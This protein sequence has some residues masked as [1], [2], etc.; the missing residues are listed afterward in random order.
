MA[1]SPRNASFSEK[2]V[3]SC[4]SPVRSNV[5]TSLC[6]CF[7]L[8]FHVSCGSFQLHFFGG[9][10]RDRLGLLIVNS[11]CMQR[12]SLSR[13]NVIASFS[14]CFY[15]FLSF[16]DSFQLHIVGGS[17]K[18]QIGFTAYYLLLYTAFYLKKQ[19]FIRVFP[20]P[21]QCYHVPF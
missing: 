21:F 14:E 6:D 4:V 11:N 16:S 17:Q 3:A 10:R 5:V 15:H 2:R 7:Y 18:H 19:I 20:F 8:R 1:T 12:F 13:F 9:L